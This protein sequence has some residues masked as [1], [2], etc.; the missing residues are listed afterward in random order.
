LRSVPE[1]GPSPILIPTHS[2]QSQKPISS[3]KSTSK[4][5]SGIKGERSHYDLQLN[6]KNSSTNHHSRSALEHL[7]KQKSSLVLSQKQKSSSIREEP[8]KTNS[9]VSN[10]FGRESRQSE[11]D[12]FLQCIENVEE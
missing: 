9:S 1:E 8:N 6:L 10:P 4:V 12:S 3:L 2:Q 7:N 5:H 11:K